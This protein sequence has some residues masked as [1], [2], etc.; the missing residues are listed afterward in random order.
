MN[1][2]LMAMLLCPEKVGYLMDR[3]LEYQLGI[4]RR[5]I[6]TGIDIAQFGDDAGATKSL[7]MKPS[8][9]RHFVKPRLK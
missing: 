5:Y 8:L 4:A 7:M 3:I 2:L 6:E 9:W 1:E